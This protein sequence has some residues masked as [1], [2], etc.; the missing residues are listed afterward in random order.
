MNPNFIISKSELIKSLEDTRKNTLGLVAGLDDDKFTMPLLEIVNPPLWEIGHVAFFYEIFVLSILDKY[1][2]IIDKADELYNSFLVDHDD[3]WELPLPNQKDTYNYLQAVLD[4]LINRL[5]DHEP[6]AEET[7]LYLLGILHEDMHVEAITYTRQTIGYPLPEFISTK[8]IANKKTYADQLTGDVEI[9]GGTFALG[10]ISDSEF[11]FDNEKWAHTIKVEPF[12]IARTVVTNDEFEEFVEAGGYENMKYWSY[13]G[14]V[15]L[16]K[17]KYKHPIYWRCEGSQWFQRHF[18]KYFLLEKHEPIMHVNWYEAEAYCN[19]S[20]RRLPTEL[21][22]ELAVS[23]EP[24]SNGCEINKS[25]RILPWGNELD[26][27]ERANLDLLFNGCV[28]VSN[29]AKGDSAFG[30]RQMIGNVWEWTYSPFYPYPGYIVDYPYKEYSAPWFGYRKVLRGGSWA[31][32]SRLIRNTYRN[33]FL[34]YR[35][36]IFAGFR[37]CAK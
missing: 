10:A 20:N 2:P 16:S 15:W 33:F 25:K 5:D 27:Y 22:W 7:Y 29:F 26:F 3:R 14:R 19:W 37:T 1:K 17:S 8:S 11:V 21:E 23:G 9:P 4:K 35:N 34:P 6:N 32:N 36:D 31:T 30:C 18:E 24:S 13:G 12:K 28:D